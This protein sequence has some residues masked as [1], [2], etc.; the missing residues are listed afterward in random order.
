MENIYNKYYLSDEKTIEMLKNAI[1]IFD[2][3]ALLDLY[4]YSEV[5]LNVIFNNVFKYLKK[6]LWIPAQV[7]FEFLKN[8]DKVSVK[9]AQSYKSLLEKPTNGTDGGHI[10]NIKKVSDELDKKAIIELKNQLKTLKEKTK[11]SDKHPYIDQCNFEG[12]DFDIAEFESH[13]KTFQEK[14]NI[15]IDNLTL[16]INEKVESINCNVDDLI[17]AM[18]KKKFTIG[19]EFT[20]SQMVDIAK[21]GE[22]RYKEE[23][24]PGYEDAKD[25]IGLQKYGDLFAWK[26]ILMYA[27][28]K[29]EDVL[30]ITNDVKEDWYDISTRA[31]RF[32]LLKEFNSETGKNFW[33]F[34]MKN[35][36]FKM[37]LLLDSDEKAL[38]AAIAEVDVI[39]HEKNNIQQVNNFDISYYKML[40]QNLWCIEIDIDND[41][42]D[43]VPYIFNWKIGGTPHLFRVI[44][45][46]GRK[47]LILINEVKGSN[48]TSALFPLRN[49][50]EIKK[51]FDDLGEEY[52]YNLFTIAPT[53][54]S[55]FALTK[56]LNRD[57]IK[58]LYNNLEVKSYV[59][60]I[61]DDEI[62]I[63]ACNY[64]V[65]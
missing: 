62:A 47:I 16:I 36:L 50:F 6:R 23:I 2:T 12:I 18:V 21:E 22:F 43:E 53:P 27:K 61:Y 8:K 11:V 65:G 40:L 38:E 49:I 10:N 25:K 45:Q 56:Q 58:L 52:E 46:D 34:N 20:Y 33:T 29:K 15:F 55:A 39:Q 31:P 1:V 7:Y 26:Q 4:Y 9:P 35:F 28:E 51:Y 17:S 19:N 32:E 63:L 5:T 3:S 24:P 54:S 44:K 64:A 42:L 13:I 41:V 30:L 57:N 48:Y 37:N 60:Y 14:I 59:G